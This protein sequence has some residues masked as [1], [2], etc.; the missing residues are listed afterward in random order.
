MIMDWL[1]ECME[2]VFKIEI[3]NGSIK[4]QTTSLPLFNWQHRVDDK[5]K[6]HL[7]PATPLEK[8]SNDK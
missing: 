4:I 1:I 2:Y 7:W 3:G 8:R 6:E 5:E